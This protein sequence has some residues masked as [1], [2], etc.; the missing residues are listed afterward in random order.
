[1]PI[2]FSCSLSPVSHCS[3]SFMLKHK[4]LITFDGTTRIKYFVTGI[5]AKLHIF[6]SLRCLRVK[7]SLTCRSNIIWQVLKIAICGLPCLRTFSNLSRYLTLMCRF[8]GN[9]L[10][11]CCTKS[12]F[13]FRL[14][15]R[16]A[17]KCS[18]DAH[19][20]QSFSPTIA[21]SSDNWL[22]LYTRSSH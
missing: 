13:V 2:L 21:Q 1:M 18:H 7:F 5:N 19:N 15:Q 17:C 3:K 20:E 10:I 11:E 9:K 6:P 16:P 22:K 12:V 14:H 8:S 4:T